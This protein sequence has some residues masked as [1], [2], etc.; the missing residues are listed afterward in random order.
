MIF[1]IDVQIDNSIVSD[2]DYFMKNFM[3]FVPT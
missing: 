2:M 3:I 1:H